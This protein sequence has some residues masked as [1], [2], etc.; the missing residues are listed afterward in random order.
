[1]YLGKRRAKIRK[2]E[3]TK[4]T[5]EVTEMTTIKRANRTYK[6]EKTRSETMK[7]RVGV[8]KIINN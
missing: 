2:L 5:P 8:T 1:M 3:N 6:L 7:E 4:E